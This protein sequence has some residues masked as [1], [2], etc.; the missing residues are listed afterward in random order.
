MSHAARYL[1]DTTALI[2]FSK[3]FEPSRSNILE[4]IDQG[5]PLAV[6]AVTVAE[7]FTGLAL[8][9]R[10]EWR[11]F[12]ATL[13]YWDI[14]TQAAIQAGIWRFDFSRQ[15]IQLATTDALVAATAWEH[16]ATLITN[17]LKH[18]PMPGIQLMSARE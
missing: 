11:E 5:L 4:L 16:R 7:F 12:F 10:Q 2:D 6:C 9:E 3:G 17:N 14:G 15:G 8:G 18:Y 13:L 1:L